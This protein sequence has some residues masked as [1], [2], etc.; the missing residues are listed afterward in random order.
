MIAKEYTLKDFQKS[1]ESLNQKARF[2]CGNHGCDIKSPQGQGTNAGCSCYPYRIAKD[3]R[4]LAGLVESA[5]RSWKHSG[6]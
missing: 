1:I 2:G 3:L 6:G 4:R 5:G